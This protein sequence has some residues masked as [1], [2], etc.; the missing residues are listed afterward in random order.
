MAWKVEV[1]D[2]R[3]RQALEQF[4]V[5]V[6]AR[7]RRVVELIQAH[8]LEHL[9]YPGIEKVDARNWQMEIQDH[10]GTKYSFYFALSG[11]TVV[12]SGTFVKE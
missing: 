8:G 11:L 1:H 12:L 3:I 7:F 4:P 5:E 6:L 9:H 10:N 2:D